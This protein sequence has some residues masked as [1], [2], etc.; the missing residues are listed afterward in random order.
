M[1]VVIIGGNSRMERIYLDACKAH[2]A[3]GKVFI[4]SKRGVKGQM[5]TPD[6]L[7]LFTSTVSHGMVASAVKE[8]ARCN[9]IVERSHSS[10]ISALN[11]IL[12]THCRSAQR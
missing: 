2:G 5:G 8:A 6:L 1:S 3:E 10:S 12:K 7:I 11:S 9:A 4:H